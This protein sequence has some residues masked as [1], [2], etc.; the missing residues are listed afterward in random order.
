MLSQ[1]ALQ[2]RGRPQIARN[3]HRAVVPNRLANKRTT[4]D[5][6]LNEHVLALLAQNNG[7]NKAHDPLELDLPARQGETEKRAENY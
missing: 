4:K 2:P 3:R 5:N 6:H 1:T 7:E